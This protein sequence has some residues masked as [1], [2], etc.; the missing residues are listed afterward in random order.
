[1]A[2]ILEAST[3]KIIDNGFEDK[4]SELRTFEG[5]AEAWNEYVGKMFKES[6]VE[7]TEKDRKKYIF[8]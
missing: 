5:K 7:I 3:L 1:M 2:A 6:G 4:I 8:T